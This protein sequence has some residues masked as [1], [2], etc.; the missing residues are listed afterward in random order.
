[1]FQNLTVFLK[2]SRSELKKVTWPT[3]EETIRYT[4]AV[5]V[6]S[7]ATAG[8]LGGADFIFKTLLTRFVI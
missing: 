4:A 1:M 7:L 3:R 2:E 8:L 6:I 5:I